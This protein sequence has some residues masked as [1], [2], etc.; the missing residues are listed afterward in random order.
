MEEEGLYT[1]KQMSTASIRPAI[2]TSLST[3]A[4]IPMGHG[5]EHPTQHEA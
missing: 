4:P 3:Q 2:R 5:T 1:V